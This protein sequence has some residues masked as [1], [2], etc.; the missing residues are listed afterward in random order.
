MDTAGLFRFLK[1]IKDK[2]SLMIGVAILTA[3]NNSEK[4]QKLQIQIFGDETYDGVVRMQEYG[5][6]TYPDPSDTNNECLVLSIC[7][8]RN[9]GVIA[10]VHNREQRPKDLQA[11]ETQMYSKFGQKIYLKADGSVLIDAGANSVQITGSDITLT[12][13]VNLKDVG[14]LAVMVESMIVKYNGHK[15][16]APNLIPDLQLTV[17][18]DS[19]ANVKA[20][21]G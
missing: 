14:G 15:H 20:Q 10:C 21:I 8:N 13:N 5:F 18:V 4:T 9:M 3:V 11:G 16:P 1:P 19:A 12:G 17:G 7:G 6:E 2:I